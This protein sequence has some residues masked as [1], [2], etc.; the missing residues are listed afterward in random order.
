MASQE[1]PEGV[2]KRVSRTGWNAL[3]ISPFATDRLTFRAEIMKTPFPEAKRSHKHDDA[4]NSYR[5]Y[6]VCLVKISYF[7][8]LS[9]LNRSHLWKLSNGALPFELVD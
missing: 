2:K 1:S 3:E 7:T 8:F 5:S 6:P 9:V 4:F